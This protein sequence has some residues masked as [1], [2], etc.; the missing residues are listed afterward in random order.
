MTR[1]VELD[2]R[3]RARA[4]AAAMTLATAALML[5]RVPSPIDDFAGGWLG[6]FPHD[7]VAHVVVFWALARS[8]L[9]AVD[10]GAGWRG[11]AWAVIGAAILYGGLLEIAQS[12]ISGRHAEGLDVVADGVGAV[13]A[14]WRR[15][16]DGRRGRGRL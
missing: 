15:G 16:G 1:A 7:K 13:L 12:V 4:W 14:P 2:G 3:R 5:V 11:R 6:A 8:W 9:A 10:A